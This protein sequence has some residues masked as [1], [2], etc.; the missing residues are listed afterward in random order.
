MHKL[1]ARQINHLL[2]VA[3][4]GQLPAIT[5]ELQRWADTTDAAGLSNSARLLILGLDDFLRQVQE[6]YCQ[7][8]RDI[9]LKTRSLQLSSIEL[10][11]TNDRLRHELDSRTRA[12]DSLRQTAISLMQSMAAE[13]PPLQ[14][15]NLESLSNLMSELAQKR[16]ESERSFQ[17][18]LSDLAKQKFALDQHAIVSMTDLAGS[19]T[20]AND[21]FCEISGYPREFLMGKNHRLINSGVQ[22]RDFFACLWQTIL[23]GQVWH[24]EICNRSRQGHVFWLQATIVPMLNAHG[25]PMQFIAIRTD[26]TERKKMEVAIGVTEAR[27][28][29]ITNAVPGVVFQCEVRDGKIRYTF[30]SER[31]FE[32]CGLSR[33]AVL[34][35]GQVV[36]ENIVSEDR[37][38]AFEAMLAAADR[39]EAWQG[40][41]RITMPDGA[42]RWI[43]SEISPEPEPATNGATVFTGIWQ[44]VTQAQ[45][46]SEE[47]QRAKLAAEVANRAKSDFLANMS[48]EI[49]T[50]MNGVMGMTELVLD[51][52]LTHEQR[53]YLN[54]VKSSSDSLLKVI[55]D[56]LDFSKIEAGKL[57]IENIAFNLEQM[58]S[59]TLKSQAVRAHTKSLELV[60]DM[61]DDVPVA[62]VGDPS[63]L[64]QILMNLI[65]N[66]IKFTENG[67]VVLR[68]AVSHLSSFTPLFQFE[69]KDSGIGISADKLHTIFEAFSQ[70]DSSITR[71]YGGT[72]LGLSISARLVNALGGQ[73]SVNSL[74]GSGSQ[75]SF[76]VAMAL[77][78]QGAPLSDDKMALAGLRV[79]VV[80]DNATSRR[81]LMR[82][83]QGLYLNVVMADSGPAALECVQTGLQQGQSFDLVLLDTHMPGMD[84]FDTAQA[85][86]QLMQPAS[87]PLVML[88]STG[89]RGDAQR[90]S[91]SGFA[92]Y[93]PKPFLR[94]DLIRVLMQVMHLASDKPSELNTR[95]TEEQAQIRLDILLVEDHIVNQQLAIALLER[96][97][98]R[99]TVADD[100]QIALVQLAL[101]PFDLVLM[102]MMMP[103][104]DGLEATRQFRATEP[105]GHHTPIIAMTANAMQ[106]DREHCLAA[107]MD[108]YISKPIDIPKLRQILARFMPLIQ[109]AR[110]SEQTTPMPAYLITPP[111]YDYAAALAASDQEV[112]EIIAHV[113]VQQWPTDLQKMHSAMAGADYRSLMRTSHALKGTLGMFGAKPCVNLAMQIEGWCQQAAD[114]SDRS[115]SS[116]R[117][118]DSALVADIQAALQTLQDQVAALLTVLSA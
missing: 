78:V 74:P 63:R 66:A 70:E 15:D 64:R 49:R 104:V 77:D 43:R 34:A 96:W 95:P 32:I 40:D 11:H 71:R 110:S 35:S 81:V 46:A 84:G 61:D 83:L 41:Y 118:D 67:Q 38:R 53:E 14:D 55:N 18:A 28:R 51:T 105:P 1:L 48:H 89:L 59:D 42:L 8:D 99:V 23:A 72:G 52:D 12:I 29:R 80:D 86:R 16:D 6:T 106:S 4:A 31:L 107:G 87:V 97:G 7:N 73:L 108:D 62:V 22:P 54:V 102:D 76:D 103:V 79:L 100:G 111:P 85:I 2:G 10:S 9:D 88:L 36:F 101:H 82:M 68:V 113:F 37:D 56:I 24:G 112:V 50:P 21:K 98:H 33:E 65:G 92:A 25:A 5:A 3:D 90:S 69:V 60:C 17:A 57:L 47:L 75:F 13:L 116:D 39:H 26:I 45:H 115:D 109:S 91:D 44:D 27:V 19:I 30:L 93:L 20:Y 58:V 114:R 94:D 117:S